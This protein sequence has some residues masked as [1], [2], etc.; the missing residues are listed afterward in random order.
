MLFIRAEDRAFD[1]NDFPQAGKKSHGVYFDDD[2]AAKPI[3]GK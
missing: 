3:V 2:A 1:L